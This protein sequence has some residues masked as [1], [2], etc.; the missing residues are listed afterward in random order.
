V[1]DELPF[2]AVVDLDDEQLAVICAE[3]HRMTFMPAGM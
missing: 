2:A 1:P 3:R